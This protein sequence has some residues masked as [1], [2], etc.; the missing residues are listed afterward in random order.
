[1]I[2][3]AIRARSRY[4]STPDDDDVVDPYRRSDAVYEQMRREITPA[5]STLVG[6][7]QKLAQVPPASRTE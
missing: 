3:L 7:N 5:T 2:P 1:M 6:W 4:R